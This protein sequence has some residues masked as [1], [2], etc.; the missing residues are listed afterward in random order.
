MQMGEI[1][2]L[3]KSLGKRRL[4]ALLWGADKNEN[5]Q[6]ALLRACPLFAFGDLFFNLYHDCAH[7]NAEGVADPVER[8]QCRLALAALN[9]T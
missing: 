2:D 8:L 9:G 5:G 6:A 3:F 7:W 4:C 1:H